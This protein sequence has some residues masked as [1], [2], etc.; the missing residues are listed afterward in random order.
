MAM[1][2]CIMA[3]DCEMRLTLDS[4]LYT[5]SS[6]YFLWVDNYRTIVILIQTIKPQAQFRFYVSTQKLRD[7]QHTFV[8]PLLLT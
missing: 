5:I 6:H 1:E 4:K 8:D 3:C 2:S 7:L